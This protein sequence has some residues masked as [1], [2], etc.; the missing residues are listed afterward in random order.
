MKNMENNTG[1]RWSPCLTPEY[2]AGEGRWKEVSFDRCYIEPGDI[3]GGA[4]N[5]D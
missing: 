5:R 1:E 3:G 2:L 4:C